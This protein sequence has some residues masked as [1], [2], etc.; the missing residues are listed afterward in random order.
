MGMCMLTDPGAVPLDQTELSAVNAEEGITPRRCKKC[1]IP[2]PPRAH[3]CS[4][5]K[6]CILKM[7]H[8]CPWVNNCVGQYNQKHFM[9]FLMYIFF[10]SMNALMVLSSRVMSCRH[11]QIVLFEHRRAQMQDGC[12]VA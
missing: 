10:M 7:D 5:C 11:R 1:Q 3:H 2:K 9:L 8:H 12:H 6:R 4:V